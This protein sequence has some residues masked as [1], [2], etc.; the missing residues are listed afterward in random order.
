MTIEEP[1]CN[2]PFERCDNFE[3]E[4]PEYT[5]GSLCSLRRS[6]PLAEYSVD[7][8]HRDSL[9][10][11]ICQ[12]VAGTRPV[13]DSTTGGFVPRHQL[14]RILSR[15]S[16]LKFLKAL[17][18]S[19][20]P[21]LFRRVTHCQRSAEEEVGI[22]CN[23]HTLNDLSINY[24]RG[25]QDE[26]QIST[27]L[28]KLFATLLLIGRPEAI[29]RFIEEGLRDTDLPLVK[30]PH[31]DKAN[32]FSLYRWGDMGGHRLSCFDDWT[33]QALVRF[34]EEQWK[35]LAPVFHLK[36]RYHVGH[37]QFAENMILP[38]TYQEHACS[39]ARGQ[40]FKVKIHPEHHDFGRVSEVRQGPLPVDV[41]S[42]Y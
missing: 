6:M 41:M 13:P 32:K 22:I 17:E 25:A 15:R 35:T 23:G 29:T 8:S 3:D 40:V 4:E 7:A 30:G 42:S 38:F 37:Y 10:G 21:S 11:H 1:G 20:N 26:A 16:L 2:K 36:D 31:R 39:G 27:G 9:A 12:A 33:H 14:L 34:E 19:R 18:A 28:C 24:V 5:F